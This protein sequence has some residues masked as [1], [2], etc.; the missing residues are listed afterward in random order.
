MTVISGSVG[1]GNVNMPVNYQRE[2]MEIAFNPH[3]FLDI[4]RDSKDEVVLFGIE[5]AYNPGL[6]TDSSNTQFVLMPMR[7][8]A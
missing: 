4:L 2:L 5:N 3:Y 6:I 7:L 1:E 8:G